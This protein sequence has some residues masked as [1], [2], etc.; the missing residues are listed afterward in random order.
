VALSGSKTPESKALDPFDLVGDVIDG[1]FRVDAVAGEGSLSLVYRGWHQSMAADVA[2]KCLNLPATLDQ[3]LVEPFVQSF[4]EGAKITYRLSRGNLNI[5][6]SLASGST[7]APRLG[8]P[9][10]YL[11]REWLEGQSL[12]AA[13]AERRAK[14]PAGMKLDE[15]IALLDGAADGL[16]FAHAQG[17]AHHSVNPTNLFVVESSG[18]RRVKLLDFGLAKAASGSGVVAGLR[19]LPPEYAAPEQ[20]DRQLGEPG[21]WTDVYSLA[22]IV[23][24]GLIGAPVFTSKEAAPAAQIDPLRRPSAR[25]TGLGLS[26]AVRE[27]IERAVALEPKKRPASVADFWSALKAA[28]APPPASVVAPLSKAPAP[29]SPT[30]VPRPPRTN[31]GGRKTMVGLGVDFGAAAAPQAPPVA[32]QPAAAVVPRAPPALA[33]EVSRPVLSQ[34]VPRAPPALAPELSQPVL[35]PSAPTPSVTPAPTSPP[36]LPIRSAF[37]PASADVGVWP[38]VRARG[39]LDRL[40]PYLTA[41]SARLRAAWSTIS[42]RLR[43]AAPPLESGPVP[44]GLQGLRKLVGLSVAISCLALLALIALAVYVVYVTRRAAVEHRREAPGADPTQTASAAPPADPFSVAP[45][46]PGAVTPVA[47]AA[48]SAGPG[49]AAPP[50]P[51]AGGPVATPTKRLVGAVAFAALDALSARLD[52]CERPGGRSGRGAVWVTFERTG[53]VSHIKVGPPFAGTPEGKCVAELFRAARV[54][55]F[56][57][58]PGAVIYKFTLPEAPSPSGPSSAATTQ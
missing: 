46:N 45:V 5:A 4:L 16:G 37:E 9:V 35:S 39:P 56:L 28:A 12:A 2:I 24:E 58:P 57:G 6:Q 17:V 10:P 20:I 49:F 15:V 29:A 34:V 42:G 48:A 25:L 51:A 13:F 30:N 36:A 21:P 31:L 43:R 44:P 55:P 19:V 32:G 8:H 26:K 50:D 18:G 33:P 54:G 27:V 11:V 7:L 14:K 40:Q 3:R 22:L 41:A 1:Q 38:I 23:M 47:A 53:T 52:N